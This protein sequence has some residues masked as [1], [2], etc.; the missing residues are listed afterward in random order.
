MNEQQN[1]GAAAG[2][3]IEKYSELVK[4]AYEVVFSG[5]TLRDLKG[6]TD[7]EMEALYA[8][9]YNYYSTGQY[10]E[11][12]TI[13]RFLVRLDHTNAKMWIGLGA[14]QQVR[15]EFSKAVASYGYASFLDLEDP[16]P[17]FYAAQCFLALGDVKNA[18]S[19]LAALDA[20]A[21]KDSPYREKAK[22]L[23]ERIDG[24]K[25]SA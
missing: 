6:V 7:G 12:D 18:E 21:P 2:L 14:V 22:K 16:K 20:Y 9:A 23:Q 24:L 11:A 17:Q 8:I 15:K 19:A 3:D 4:E 10:E 1:N 13:F 25:K 5:G